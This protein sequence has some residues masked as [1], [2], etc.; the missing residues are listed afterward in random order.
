MSFHL[1]S[2]TPNN[3]NN[4][5]NGN[6]VASNFFEYDGFKASV[7]GGAAAAPHSP[8]D[9]NFPGAAQ[10]NEKDA[11]LKPID[12]FSLAKNTMV[13]DR[14]EIVCDVELNSSRNTD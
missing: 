2:G 10:K 8:M 3:N 9:G 4:N 1:N 14:W 11:G 13:K 6:Q 5:I 7:N 12:T